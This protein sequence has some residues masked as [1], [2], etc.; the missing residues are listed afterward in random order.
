MSAKPKFDA[1]KLMA[2]KRFDEPKV[3][4]AQMKPQGAGLLLRI[5]RGSRN[6]LRRGSILKRNPDN[7]SD[8][9]SGL[10]FQ[11]ERD[12]GLPTISRHKWRNNPAAEREIGLSRQ[13][14]RQN[15]GIRSSNRMYFGIQPRISWKSDWF[16]GAV[17]RIHL[18]V[19]FERKLNP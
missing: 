13:I 7:N 4:S 5:D 12:L 8:R 14:S 9:V 15:G 6:P 19:R 1:S 10:Q 17:S 11:G 18:H 2:I 16:H 3:Q